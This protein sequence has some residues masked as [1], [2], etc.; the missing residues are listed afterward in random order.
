MVMH[1]V[2]RPFSDRTAASSTTNLEV[3][4]GGRSLRSE[5]PDH[6]KRRL[7]D[8]VIERVYDIPVL[9][10]EFRSMKHETLS[11]D[12]REIVEQRLRVTC[13]EFCLGIN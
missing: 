12:A 3:C 5:P 11:M 9:N 4:M 1:L 7:A 13:D 6:K 2:T 8:S 10:C